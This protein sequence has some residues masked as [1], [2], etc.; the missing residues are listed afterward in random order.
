MFH[1][2]ILALIENKEKSQRNCYASDFQQ[3][4][5]G[6]LAQA[7]KFDLLPGMELIPINP[8][9]LKPSNLQKSPVQVLILLFAKFESA[10][11]LFVAN[12]LCKN[13]KEGLGSL[14]LTLFQLL[15]EYCLK[16]DLGKPDYRLHS[17]VGQNGRQL[18]LYRVSRMNEF[19]SRAINLRTA[20]L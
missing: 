11:Q 8:H 5:S 2:E 14:T 19:V 6:T 17:A 13:W 16:A 7:E 18:F 20:F 9:S 10:L 3:V 4:T 15:E 12:L 1:V